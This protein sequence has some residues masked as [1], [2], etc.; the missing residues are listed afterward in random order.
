MLSANQCCCILSCMISSELISHCVHHSFYYIN[1]G[2]KFQCTISKGILY[3]MSVEQL[4][5]SKKKIQFRFCQ[6]FRDQQL[7]LVSY[8]LCGNARLVQL[9]T[10][11]FNKWE[12]I[13]WNNLRMA[14]HQSK[15]ASQKCGILKYSTENP[16]L[17]AAE[18][19]SLTCSEPWNCTERSKARVSVGSLE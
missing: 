15:L 8:H 2:E 1:L 12:D 17:K 19:S 4:K 5:K 3:F 10:T 9:L 11:S 7:Q 14:R 16:K 6:I 13:L 18:E